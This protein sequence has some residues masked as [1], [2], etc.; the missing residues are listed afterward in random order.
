ML[1][2]ILTADQMK[3]LDELVHESPNPRLRQRCQALLFSHR[4]YKRAQIA[5][6][7]SVKVDTVTAWF[8]RW[9]NNQQVENLLDAPRSGRKPKLDAAKKKSH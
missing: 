8:R 7:F 6:L 2:I 1:K 4:G 3:Q 5:Q 9:K